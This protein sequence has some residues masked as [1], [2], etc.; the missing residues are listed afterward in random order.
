M[1]KTAF[2]EAYKS[3]SDSQADWGKLPGKDMFLQPFCMTCQKDLHD[4]K[5]KNLIK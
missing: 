5:E 1:M 3:E 2:F 4:Y